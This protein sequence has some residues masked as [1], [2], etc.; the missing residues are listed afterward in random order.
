L[1][2][3]EVIMKKICLH[4][5]WSCWRKCWQTQTVRSLYES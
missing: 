4:R 3:A 1:L 2:L 5:W